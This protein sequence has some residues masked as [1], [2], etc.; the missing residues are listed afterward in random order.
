M[1]IVDVNDVEKIDLVIDGVDEVDSVFN[2]I[3]GGG[4][5][6]FREKVI[7][8]MVDWF[9]VVVDESKFVNYLGEIF[10]LLVEVDKFNWY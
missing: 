3:K 10:V 4:G 5:V 6:L 2:F 1:N 8:E 9:V 7:D